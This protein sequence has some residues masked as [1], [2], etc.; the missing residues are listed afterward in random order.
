[1]KILLLIDSLGVGGAETHVLDLARELAAMG[2][3]ITVA[4]SGGECAE[5]LSALGVRH[6]RLRHFTRGAISSALAYLRLS[7][8]IRRERFDIIHAHSRRA[9]YIGERIAKR[10]GVCF[11][12][13][14][15]ALFSTSPIK[16]YMS[17]WGYYVSAVS[18]DIAAYLTREYGVLP[19]RISVIPNGVDTDYFSPLGEVKSECER[20]IVFVSR[21]DADCSAA[22]YALCRMADRLAERYGKIKISI[23]GGGSEYEPLLCLAKHM[24][25]IIGY[26]AVELLGALSD[27]RCALCGADVFVGVSRAAIEAMAF[28][29]NTVLAGN[30]GF[31]GV[32]TPE[33]VPH[34]AED[35]FCGRESTSLDPERFFCDVCAVLDMSEAEARSLSEG[36]REYI[37][38]RH[39]SK[40]CAGLYE[41]F[42]LRAIK[43]TDLSGRGSCICG[44]YGFGNLGDDTL[45]SESIK[46]CRLRF[47]GGIS[48]LTRKPR[49]DRYAFGVRCVRRSNPISVWREIAAS[50]R[51]I[52]GGGTLF[53]D[54][55]SLRS[56]FYYCALAEIAHLHGVRVELWGNGLGEIKSRAG[57]ALLRRVL[58]GAHYIGLRDKHSIEYA[59]SLGADPT[60]VTLE[61]DLAYATEPTP[62]ARVRALAASRSPLRLL[63][64]IS[65]GTSRA[66]YE[67]IKKEI[68]AR[69]RLGA[70]VII[71]SMYP[72]EDD[73]ISERLALECDCK[74]ISGLSGGELLYLSAQSGVCISTRFHLLVFGERAGCELIGG[75]DDPKIIFFCKEKGGRLI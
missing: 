29:I 23:V 55:T 56:L 42:Y 17:R 67:R 38:E 20:R 73:R 10:C 26:S 6:I 7:R 52:F 37:L 58:S 50:E 3:G 1:M 2:H 40:G 66:I 13:T 75:G 62:S 68:K 21:L 30:E 74:L 33:S 22:A 12:T 19:E 31:F 4:S 47:D 15:H 63:V 70:E 36:V 32:V 25:R 64:S 51:L 43:N 5:R 27:V 8:L 60:K 44:Y 72:K 34:A 53:Q 46:L 24:N 59:L 16:K 69:A 41:N 9:A 18:E 39:S 71:V 54:R 14:A 57:R 45:L 61:S 65:G 49:R 35:N 48:A 11:V 28:G